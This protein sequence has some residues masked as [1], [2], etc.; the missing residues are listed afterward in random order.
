MSRYISPECRYLSPYQ[1]E[2]SICAF[3][4]ILPGISCSIHSFFTTDPH[5][6]LR[7]SRGRRWNTY[8]RSIKQKQT[9]IKLR[10]KKNSFFHQLHF[11]L[12]HTIFYSVLRLFQVIN[13][14]L[15]YI[16]FDF[17]ILIY[18]Y[19]NFC[20]NSY[21]VKWHLN[22]IFFFWMIYNNRGKYLINFFS[23][24]RKIETE[25]RK[26]IIAI[27]LFARGKGVA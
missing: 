15:F 13:I 5:F 3:Q 12:L 4:R 9:W 2:V 1:V 14:H 18:P 24:E 7:F 11:L 26:G 23:E 10:R 25:K 27:F 21:R 17:E 22:F 8:N 19:I 6:L 20:R 16:L